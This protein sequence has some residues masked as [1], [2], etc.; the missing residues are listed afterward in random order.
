MRK[1]TSPR[2]PQREKVKEALIIKQRYQLNPKQQ[3]ILETALDKRIKC[4]M[5]DG[6]WGTSK[7]F[8]AVF[9]SLQLLSEKK[10][11]EIIYIRN[12]VESSS[13]G[14]M[15]YLKGDMNEKLAP[16]TAPFEEKLQ[17]F[18]SPA[19][20]KKLQEDQRLTTMALGFIRGRS[21]N[22]KAIIVDEAASMTFDD[23]ILILTRCGPFTKIFLIGDSE[24]QNDIG[25]KTGFKYLFDKLSDAESKENG[26]ETFEMK[27]EE[28]IV[29]SDFVRFVLKKVGKIKK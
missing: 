10:V 26:I 14:K 5:I 19:I 4:V 1:D 6:L 17:E 18:L 22:C 27:S 8:L 24:N 20:I 21:F 9:A 16:Y 2:I 23:L 3:A 7:T 25:A 12:P 11:D 15:G 29:R 13:S 28:D